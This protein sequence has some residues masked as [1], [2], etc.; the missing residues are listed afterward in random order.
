MKHLETQN[1]IL[2]ACD[3]EFLEAGKGGERELEKFLQI[4]F[5]E[6]WTEF[7]IEMFAYS[8]GLLRSDTGH[9]GWLTYLPMHK[10]DRVILGT[11]GYKGKPSSEGT[12]EIGYEIAPG[13]R[14]RGLAT[15]MALALVDHAF[16]NDEVTCILAH[17]LKDGLASAKV[18]SKCGFTRAGEVLDPEDG[19][20]YRWEL[21]RPKLTNSLSGETQ[22]AREGREL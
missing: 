6:N 12:V 4:R 11:G 20:V 9:Q 14:N 17:T 21:R 18:L 1:M 5:A 16:R 22:H 3:L 15:E 13:Y 19:P 7:G 8:L 10:K 2:L